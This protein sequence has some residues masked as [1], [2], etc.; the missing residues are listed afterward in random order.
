MRQDDS[1]SQP[2]QNPFGPVLASL[3]QQPKAALG[4]IQQNLDKCRLS[5]HTLAV[6]VAYNIQHVARLSGVGGQHRSGTTYTTNGQA[7]ISRTAS[8]VEVTQSHRHIPV[9]ERLS[10]A[11][12]TTGCR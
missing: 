9:H 5:L 6:T 2:L 12:V 4:S 3:G 10:V 11:V 8:N 1:R 7:A